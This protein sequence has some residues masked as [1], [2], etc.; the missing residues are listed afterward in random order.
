[1]KEVFR[2]KISETDC[3]RRGGAEFG[4]YT[5]PQVEL[6]SRGV[7]GKRA[8]GGLHCRLLPSLQPLWL[9]LGAGAIM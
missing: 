1:M 4:R 5:T 9:L 6:S 7:S 8:Q 3:Q 2:G